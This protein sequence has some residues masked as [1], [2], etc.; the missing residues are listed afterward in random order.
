MVR[1]TRLYRGQHSLSKEASGSYDNFEFLI[2]NFEIESKFKIRKF[3]INLV[4]KPNHKWYAE[5]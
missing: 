2:T 5:L 1:R 4:D 3:E